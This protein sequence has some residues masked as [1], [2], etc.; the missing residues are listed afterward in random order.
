MSD[1]DEKLLQ[2][3]T[4]LEREVE[5]LRVKE[6]PG[7]WLDWTP[8]VTGWVAGYS[9][10][11]RYCKVGKM[12]SVK[13]RITG[14]SDSTSVYV[15]LPFTS[16]SNGV[17]AWAYAMDAG[18]AKETPAYVVLDTTSRIRAY[19]TATGTPWTAS[20]DKRLMTTFTYEAA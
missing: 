16:V 14:T 19:L 4:K 10:I 20:G 5:R 17:N 1:F 11:A 2:R 18:T 15:T 6:S 7:A 8:T 12:V 9:C 3:L 13:I